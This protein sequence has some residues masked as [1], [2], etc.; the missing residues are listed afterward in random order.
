[1]KQLYPLLFTALVACVSMGVI[2]L[3]QDAEG[4][5]THNTEESI[6]FS[7]TGAA[8]ATA[9]TDIFSIS[10]KATSGT[11]KW[12]NSDGKLISIPIAGDGSASG[13]SQTEAVYY[14]KEQNGN[15]DDRIYLE[16]EACAGTTSV[17]D[18][19]GAQFLVI[20][21]Q[22][23]HLFKIKSINTEKNQI[24]MEDSSYE[25][26]ANNLQYTDGSATAFT[27]GDTT[28]FLTI[29]EATN[30]ISFTSIGSSD[31]AT[32][33]LYDKATLELVNTNTGTQIVEGF[34]FSEYA[35]GALAASKYIGHGT[36]PALSIEIVYDD[37]YNNQIEISNNLLTDLGK[38]Q[39][40]GWY[41]TDQTRSFYTNKGT[42]FTYAEEKNKL[43][44][45]YKKTTT[46]AIVTIQKTTQETAQTIYGVD[47]QG[48]VGRDSS[49]VLDKRGNAYISYF[50]E[51][52]DA[53]KYA[54]ET[55]DGWYVQ[56]IDTGNVGR[57]SAIA[58]DTNDLPHIIYTDTKNK[59]LKYA[60]YDGSQWN[61][62]IIEDAYTT[63]VNPT[64]ALDSNNQ[65]RIA[66]YDYENDNLLYMKY[67]A[68][69]QQWETEIVD[70]KGDVGANPSMML[71][72]D[73]NPHIVYFENGYDL[74]KY[75]HEERGI[76][77]TMI[78]DDSG[79]MG[80]WTSIQAN[81]EGKLSLWY[82][83]GLLDKAVNLQYVEDATWQQNTY[84]LGGFALYQ[85]D[86]VVDDSN[87]LHI[88]YYPTEEKDLRYVVTELG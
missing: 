88:T 2:L 85:G 84:D 52:N 74:V 44:I 33:E 59:Q 13:Q 22:N 61:L 14:G 75:A 16:S 21:R 79:S 8:V 82:Y 28:I 36:N 39:G 47:T 58:L 6:Y 15:P 45:S 77:Q 62:W 66:F 57:E 86:L 76:W 54:Y 83:N 50:D 19:V 38:A 24:S 7:L 64:I 31:G 70:E 17:E 40:S 78:I 68:E 49:L 71:D 25:K 80:L 1:M 46:G 9:Q 72:S 35:D 4:I 63:A 29:N 42:L 53:L 65:P 10:A 51:T 87:Y 26:E 20:A 67:D 11:I 43:T 27:I 5:T 55:A 18:C 41:T 48:D 60:N 30:Q 69:V 73:D 3:I 12:K 32:I 34:L 23:A 56:T 37:L 81:A